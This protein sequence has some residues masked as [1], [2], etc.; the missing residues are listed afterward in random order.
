MRR[1]TIEKT[2][3]HQ[4]KRK[5]LDIDYCFLSGKNLSVDNPKRISEFAKR[6][7]KTFQKR[8]PFNQVKMFHLF[9]V[10]GWEKAFCKHSLLLGFSALSDFLV[11]LKK[12]EKFLMF[13]ARKKRSSSLKVTSSRTFQH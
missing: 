1:N 7:S 13:P 5:A 2:L 6:K 4:T 11:F 12:Y 10:L 9:D 3:Q 8:V